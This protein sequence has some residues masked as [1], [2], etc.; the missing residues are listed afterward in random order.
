[1]TPQASTVAMRETFLIER[2][3]GM[4]C[5]L[6]LSVFVSF[7]KFCVIPASWRGRGSVFG[8]DFAQGDLGAAAHFGFGVP[9]GFAQGGN[10]GGGRWTYLRKE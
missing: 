9:Q 3:R 5:S 10:G 1:M 8:I 4:V 6:L 2:R 7:V